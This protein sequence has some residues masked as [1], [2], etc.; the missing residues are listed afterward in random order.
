MKLRMLAACAALAAGTAHA[1]LF[2]DEEA[3]KAIN[4]LNRRVDARF[5]KL[6]QD[7]NERLERR[8]MLDL[9]AQLEGIR[10]DLAALRGQIEVLQN[11]VE[12]L[13]RRQKDLYTDVDARL[14][15]LEPQSAAAADKGP[16]PQAQ[17]QQAYEAA[18]AQMKANN[19]GAAIQGLQAFLAQYP[20]STLAPSAQYWIGNAYFALRD[21]KNAIAAQNRVVATW[22]D[23]AKAPDALLNIA[24][25]QAELGDVTG[26]RNTLKT[27]ISKYPTSP[28]AE[29]AKQRLAKTASR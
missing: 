14:R 10:N 27:L 29:Q 11:R 8:S 5:A 28:A 13:D 25:S 9:T 12:Q 17:E 18:L 3:R 22:P 4:D 7:L 15:K 1:G 19:Y 20:Q 2:D 16:A 24:S 6:E 26:S 21:F 23:N